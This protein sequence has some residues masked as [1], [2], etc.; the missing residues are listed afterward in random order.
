MLPHSRKDRSA[1]PSRHRGRAER[2]RRTHDTRGA[3]PD[4]EGAAEVEC[5]GRLTLLRR[6]DLTTPDDAESP[7]KM[8]VPFSWVESRRTYDPR[9][10]DSDSPTEYVPGSG[11]SWPGQSMDKDRIVSP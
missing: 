10:P 5:P 8:M 4:D 9:Q 3:L 11:G 1:T 6:A 7:S 2:P